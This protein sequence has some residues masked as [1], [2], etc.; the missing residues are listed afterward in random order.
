MLPWVIR[1]LGLHLAGRKYREMNRA[2]EYLAGCEAVEVAIER[3][4]QLAAER[5]LSPD[6]L[7]AIRV[8]HR[9]RL[10]HLESP[11]TG[12]DGHKSHGE[13]HDEVEHLLIAAERTRINELFRSGKLK[14]EARRRIERELDLRDAHLSNQRSQV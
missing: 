6:V 9:D 1:Q 5:D 10:K 8:R 7:E 4:D 2:E 14:D 12:D 11:S 3:L 13:L